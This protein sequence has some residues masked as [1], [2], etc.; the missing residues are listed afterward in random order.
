MTRDDD[1]NEVGEKAVA[2]KGNAA[3]K[4]SGDFTIMVFSLLFFVESLTSTVGGD[5]L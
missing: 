4:T 2:I 1:G 3:R 5:V